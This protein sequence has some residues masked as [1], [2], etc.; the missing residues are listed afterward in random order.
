MRG[1]IDGDEKEKRELVF[2]KNLIDIEQKTITQLLVDEVQVR[3]RI[4]CFLADY[5]GVSSFLHI[6][7]RQFNTLVP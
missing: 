6:P 2:G 5:I 3:Y 1:G 7:N 4:S